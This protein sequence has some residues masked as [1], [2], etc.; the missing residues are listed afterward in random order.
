[1]LKVRRPIIVVFH[2]ALVIAAYVL[3]F[4]LRLD[5]N[6]DTS[7][8]LLI[9]RTLLLVI[10]IKMAA[11]GYFGLFS[12]LWRYAGIFDIWRIFKVHVLAT[13]C[14]VLAVGGFYS[15][16]GYPRSIFAL[17]FILSFCL[18]AGVRFVTR[19]FR[20]RY[21]PALAGKRR[22]AIIIGAGEAGMMVLREARLNAMANIEI[23][24]FIDDDQHKKGS[25]MQGVRVL[26]GRNDISR[27]VEQ[28]MIDE[29]IIAIPSAKGEVIR[30]NIEH[31]QISSVKI[32]IVPGLQKILSG[33]LEVKPRNVRPEDLLG[34]ETVTVNADEIS[35]YLSRKVVLVT[36]AGG[37]IGSCL[38]RQIVTFGPKEVLLFDHN[39]NDVYYLVIEFLK[40]YP[41][42]RFRASSGTLEIS[43][44]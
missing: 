20:E 36:G 9:K 19:I 4:Y 5:F 10:C 14:L 28:Y 33:E 25:Y 37:S 31:C 39:E 44:F 18:V 6:I 13:L 40:K 26:G 27:V 38:C 23:V 17:D 29:I 32:R 2:L 8:W 41:H 34:R 43:V 7:Y 16:V 12:G 24:G 22:K 11:F 1:L 15:F 42:I 35:D 21:R 30:S 3:A